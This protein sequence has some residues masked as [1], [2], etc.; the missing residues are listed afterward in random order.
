MFSHIRTKIIKVLKPIIIKNVMGHSTKIIIAVGLSAIIPVAVD[1]WSTVFNSF[2]G[3]MHPNLPDILLFI[4]ILPVVGI[5]AYDYGKKRLHEQIDNKKYNPKFLN[6]NVF[7]KWMRVEY[8]TNYKG[9]LSFEIPNDERA[10]Q[11]R[12]SST[13]YMWLEDKITGRGDNS[14]HSSIETAIPNL[15][16]GER[17]LEVNYKDVFIHWSNIKKIRAEKINQQNNHR[18]FLNLSYTNS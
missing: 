11:N 14:D 18:R 6:D 5:S 8:K 7:R 10:L 15:K 3:N 4:M 13:Y 9:D 17:Y 12:H 16:I 2:L 1:R